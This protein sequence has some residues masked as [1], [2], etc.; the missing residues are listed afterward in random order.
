[1]L[2]KR[3]FRVPAFSVIGFD[4]ISSV[5]EMVSIS[6]ADAALIQK[7][8]GNGPFAVRSALSGED[9]STS[10]M[11]GQFVTVLPVE[12]NKLLSTIKEVIA[13]NARRAP[14]MKQSIIVQRCLS[15]EK[16]GV[17]FTRSPF[18]PFCLQ[19][20]EVTGY[21]E[22]LVSGHCDADST[23]IS[24]RRDTSLLILTKIALEIERLFGHPQDI[25]WSI[26]KGELFILQ[27][28]PITT[29]SARE[30]IAF[31]RIESGIL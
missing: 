9:T 8:V 16:S 3:G 14:Q 28:R 29:L 17:V 22:G 15:P 27:A 25:E 7:H 23:Y 13:E 11:A 4:Q 1:M 6:D 24:R 26:E 30:A 12:A 19:I 10:S 2:A 21:G 31:E 5:A 18:D 20:D